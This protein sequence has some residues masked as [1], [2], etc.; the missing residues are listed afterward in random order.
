M[1]RRPSCIDL[2]QTGKSAGR[3]AVFAAGNMQKRSQVPSSGRGGHLHTESVRPSQTQLLPPE[4]RILP[5]TSGNDLCTFPED[6]KS[7]CNCLFWTHVLNLEYATIILQNTQI[8]KIYFKVCVIGERPCAALSVSSCPPPLLLRRQ[9]KR[10]PV[11]LIKQT[12]FFSFFFFG[13]LCSRDFCQFLIFQDAE[14]H[15]ANQR[16]G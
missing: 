2:R 13:S 5:G 11:C 6:W 15:L 12:G 4:V 3:Q 1:Q 16:L 7:A 9:G 8:G 10:S 14:G